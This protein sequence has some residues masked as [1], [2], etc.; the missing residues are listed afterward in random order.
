[1]HETCLSLATT[2]TMCLRKLLTFPP[3]VEVLSRSPDTLTDVLP[4]VTI[5]NLSSEPGIAG[6]WD[7]P[8]FHRS[9]L[10]ELVCK[11]FAHP[12]HLPSVMRIA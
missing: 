7:E 3:V 2:A 9:L 11:W 10:K 8:S 12:L 1:V 6:K 4:C 5:I